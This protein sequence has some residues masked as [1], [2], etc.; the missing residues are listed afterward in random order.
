MTAG[1]DGLRRSGSWRTRVLCLAGL[2]ASGLAVPFA[3]GEDAK[4]AWQP[5]APDGLPTKFDW[6]RLPSDEWL[7]GKI[8]S[9]YDGKLEF[10]SDELGVHTFDFADI[11]EIRTSRVV[12]VGFA[13]REPAM[14]QLMLEGTAARVVAQAG[15]TAFARSEILTIVVGSAR[16][17]DYWSGY[18]NVGGNIRSGNSDQV[19]YTA[20]LGTMR[21]SVKDR[22]AFD[23]I[24]TLTRIDSVDTS[25]NHRVTLG[26]D[27][28]LTKRLFLN[29]VGLEWYRDRF[30]NVANRWTV[31]AGLGYELVDT[32]RTSWSATLGPAWQKSD[33]DSSPLDGEESSDSFALRVGTRFDHEFTKSIDFHAYYSAFFTDDASG[34]YTHHFDTG[35]EIELVGDLDFN[36]AWVWDRVQDPRPL[37][38][39]SLPQ[40]DD[41]RLVFGLGWSF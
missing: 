11:K 19:D 18:A 38:D 30:Q 9:M 36:L 2:L 21:R 33:W 39:G 3:R 12:Q 35:L 16:E 25:N 15:E 8:V 1:S 6:I 17:I 29:L 24:G 41:T 40:Q 28:F 22:T 32:A 37:E 4:G 31:T 10:D 26:W 13:G 27:R 14:G 20:R 34:T 23:Y 5:K 7:K